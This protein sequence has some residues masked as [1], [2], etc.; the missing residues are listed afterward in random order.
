MA[1]FSIKTVRD[2]L[3]SLR[4]NRQSRREFDALVEIA[5]ILGGPIE[6]RG[7]CELMVRLLA[8]TANADMATLRALDQAGT[9]L[10]LVASYATAEDPSSSLADF[11][12]PLTSGDCPI[13]RAF[14]ERTVL[15]IGDSAKLEIPLPDYYS[16]QSRSLLICPVQAGE[17]VVGVL[18]FASGA[19]NNFNAET[20]R[21]MTAITGTIGVLME[22]ASLQ[23]ERALGDDK[24]VRLAQA[25]EFTDDAIALVDA[26]GN[27][28]YMNKAALE[29][30]GDTSLG[31]PGNFDDFLAS[32][33]GGSSDRNEGI[34]LQALDGGWSGEF[35]RLNK[36]G[37]PIDISFA[38]NPVMDGDNRVMGVI[39]VGR[40]VTE[41]R[42]MERD[43]LRLNKQREVEAN[44]GRIV[45]YPLNMTDVFER[46]A[47]EFKKIVPFDRITILSVDLAHETYNIEFIFGDRRS[48]PETKEPRPFEGS[49]TGRL[50]ESGESHI[51]NSDSP[52]FIGAEIT[53]ARPIPGSAFTSFLGVPLN[54]G[55]EIVGVVVLARAEEAFTGEEQLLAERV[56]N[57]LSG[58]LATYALNVER[59]NAVV[60]A[61]ESEARFRQIADNIRGAF[62]LSDL[63]PHKLLYISPSVSQIWGAPADSFYDQPLRW[64]EL[65]H[66]DDR[67]RVEEA[68]ERAYLTGELY[69][70]FRIIRSDGSLRW[71]AH[72]GFPV[73]DEDG[74]VYRIGGFIEDITERKETDRRLS[75]SE[76]MASIGELSAGVAHEINNPLTSIV[77]YSQML[78]D[79]DIPDSI[80]SDLQAISSQAY[81]AAKI[82]R[83][84]LQFAR[85]SD[86]DKRPL[87]IAGLIRRSLEMK[88]HDFNVNN[89]AIVED[90][91][92]DL[93]LIIMD[94]HLIIQVLL[95]VL[96][97]A[98][99]ACVSAHGRGEITVSVSTEQTR[100]RISIR[101]NGPGIPAD[102]I[103]KVFEP[104]FTTKDVGFGTGLGLSVS[105]GILS[106]HEGKIWVESDPGAG[107]TFHIE[108]PV[109]EE[110]GSTGSPGDPHS[111]TVTTAVKSTNH[112][113]VVD[114]EPDLR[115]VLTKQLE[116][117][118]FNVD[119]AGDGEEAW[120]K[121][122]TLEYDCI[123][124]DLRM[125]GLGGQGLYERLKQMRPELVDRII[126]I[127]GDTVNPASKAFLSSVANPV[128]SKPFDFRELE[129]LVVSITNRRQ[130]VHRRLSGAH[131]P[132]EPGP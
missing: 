76:R 3:A 46:F 53:K 7:K 75:E 45:S 44:I 106:Q 14:R 120:R 129:Q 109:T 26:Q 130:P 57:L 73:K 114:D 128:L 56:G 33:V 60:E 48:V 17:R 71:V 23:E 107:A 50:V 105:L 93:P 2:F 11:A 91:P 102:Q 4:L 74:A 123:L 117:K 67:Q 80:R 115:T 38:T 119:Q 40:D 22:N 24:I 29:L 99:Q 52:A 43:L 39:A 58:A 86:P 66:P 35:Q 88:S 70:E 9:G 82:V 15:V 113:L 20:V 125:P 100:V 49:I 51:Y 121:L 41:N 62:W 64:M 85:K 55:D 27:L 118:R 112:I 110:S 42:R 19:T 90:I 37:K 5:G 101:D 31:S 103:G 69:E 104:F 78:L 124:L 83:N 18:G 28:E 79:E 122:Q 68:V 34:L 132:G 6:F 47:N 8:H 116:L 81:R 87:S 95:N 63:R 54:F 111:S 96:T 1:A 89:I 126:F 98:E 16:P 108:L 84:L 94:E 77:L 25:L 131:G 10:R 36:D 127:T 61:K 92:A 12:L 13:V 97:N 30:T 65:V 59:N 21:L 72:R 32:Q